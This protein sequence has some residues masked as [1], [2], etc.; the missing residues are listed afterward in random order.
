MNANPAKTGTKPYGNPPAVQLAR[1]VGV[2]EASY[3]WPRHE[4]EIPEIRNLTLYLIIMRLPNFKRV[5]TAH[6]HGSGSH[7][8]GGTCPE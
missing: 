8:S 4:V 1:S 6:V 7:L 5:G 3:R 2:L